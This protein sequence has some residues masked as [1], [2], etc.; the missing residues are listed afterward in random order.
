MV[1][2]TAI[3]ALHFQ[4]TLCKQD[5]KR[6]Q[7][8]YGLKLFYLQ[9]EPCGNLLIDRMCILARERAMLSERM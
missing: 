6:W 2:I 3:I 7:S 9:V 8:L 4:E 5:R 1:E